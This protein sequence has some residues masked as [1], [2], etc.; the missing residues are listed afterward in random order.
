MNTFMQKKETVERNWYVIDASGVNL[1]RL[2]SKV[3][4]VL[5]DKTPLMNSMFKK[6]IQGT[7]EIYKIIKTAD[8][9]D[10]KIVDLLNALHEEN[11]ALKQ[12]IQNN[13]QHIKRLENTQIKTYT[14]IKEAYNN[15]RTTLGKSV[16]KQL[17]EQME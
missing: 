7:R 4:T 6:S 11:Q 14:T 17:L 2:A 9:D 16:L 3:A 10:E 5:L 8:I 13:Y 15:E 12:H 1:G